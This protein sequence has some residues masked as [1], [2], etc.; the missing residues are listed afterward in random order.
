MRERSSRFLRRCLLT[1]YRYIPWPI[2][3]PSEPLKWSVHLHHV[4]A[5]ICIAIV[6]DAV[7]LSLVP[8]PSEAS[9]LDRALS[10]GAAQLSSIFLSAAPAILAI[11]WPAA[12]VL[13][14]ALPCALLRAPLRAPNMALAVLACRTVMA[15]VTVVLLRGCIA[16]GELCRAGPFAHSRNPI[17]VSVL[18]LAASLLVLAPSAPNTLGTVWLAIHLDGGVRVEEAALHG[19]FGDAWDVYEGSVSR[20]L[21][22]PMCA[23]FGVGLLYV[24]WPCLCQLASSRRDNLYG[25]D[26]DAE[27]A[28]SDRL[29]DG[30]AARACTAH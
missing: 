22:P 21:S 20:W 27:Q 23:A 26:S 18:L 4:R 19:R 3:P 12:C 15:V 8:I 7:L 6:I 25:H 11:V 13:R 24:L 16:R 17:A 29:L 2:Y 5:P 30:Y 14:L 10:G 9:A 1:I 28:A